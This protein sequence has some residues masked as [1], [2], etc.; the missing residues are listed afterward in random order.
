MPGNIGL[1]A[2]ISVDDGT[3]TPPANVVDFTDV[4]QITVPTSDINVVENS[5]LGVLNRTRTY[6]AGLIDPGMMDFTQ[7][8]TDDAYDRA[9]KLRGNAHNWTI[10]F[11][12]TSKAAFAGFV[13]KVECDIAALDQIVDMKLSVKVTGAVTFT[14]TP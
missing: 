8:Y 11:P 7:R 1:G 6:V 12:D 13:T 14:P 2:K 4:T 3:G 5:H 10:T 9:L